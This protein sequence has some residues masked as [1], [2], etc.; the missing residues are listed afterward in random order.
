MTGPLGELPPVPLIVETRRSMHRVAEHVLS[1]ALKTATGQIALEPGPGGFRTPPL[2]DGRVVAVEGTDITVTEPHGV[3]RVRLTTL[4][5]AALLAG[6]EAGFPWTKYPPATPMEPDE[7]LV[8]DP[9]AAAVIAG[10]FALGVEALGALA[11]AIPGDAPSRAALH[12]EHFDLAIV[13]AEVNYGVSPGDDDI[14]LPY[15]YV[16]PHEGPP[17]VDDFWNAP[18]GAYR[19][20]QD[21]TTPEAATAFFQDGRDRLRGPRE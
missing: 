7:P 9:A 2:P 12:P 4:A 8:V 3:R 11:A 14:E 19:T 10:W 6:I 5:A 1:A 21:V 20:I 15:L 16:G 17:A 18:F 13:A